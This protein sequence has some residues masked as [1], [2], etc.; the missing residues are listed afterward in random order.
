VDNYLNKEVKHRAF[1]CIVHADTPARN[2]L[3]EFVSVASFLACY[4]C[5]FEG[6]KYLDSRTGT[7]FR[8]YTERAPQ[9]VR[10]EG[11]KVYTSEAKPRTHKDHVQHGKAVESGEER[12]EENGNKGLSVLAKFLPYFDLVKGFPIPLARAVLLGVVK[13]FWTEALQKYPLEAERP[14][15][16]IPNKKR[17]VMESKGEEL[18]RRCPHDRG[19]PPRCIVKHR[20][21]FVMED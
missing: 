5:W 15:G 20:G 21:S 9:Y 16:V 12:P 17:W 13:S 3:L 1:L 18:K 19:R 7:Y 2:K 6:C 8:G 10:K 14:K 11:Q 4:R